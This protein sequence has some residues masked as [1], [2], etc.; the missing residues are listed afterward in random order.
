M[1]GDAILQYRICNTMMLGNATMLGDAVILGEA[2]L[3]DIVMLGS[4][5]EMVMQHH[6]FYNVILC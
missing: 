3:G 2:M 4:Y 1:L 6:I 5:S